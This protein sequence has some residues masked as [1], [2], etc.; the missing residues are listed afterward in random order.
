MK[1]KVY[2]ICLLLITL[3]FVGCADKGTSY[4]AE[5]IQYDTLSDFYQDWID[6]STDDTGYHEFVNSDADS[7]EMLIYYPNINKDGAEYISYQCDKIEIADGKIKVYITQ[8]DAVDDSQVVKDLLLHITAPLRGAWPSESELFID[9][10]SMQ[11]VSQ[12]YTM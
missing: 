2:S 3:F 9:G 11:C 6:K 12:D 5:F 7:W 4:K 8:K 10:V 1:Q